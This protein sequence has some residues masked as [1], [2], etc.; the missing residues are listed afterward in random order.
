MLRRPPRFTR[1]D[2]LFPYTTLF[3]SRRPTR[4]HSQFRGYSATTSICSPGPL[5]SRSD[6]N[7]AGFDVGRSRYAAPDVRQFRSEEHTSELQSLMRISYAVFCL[8]KNKEQLNSNKNADT[9]HMK[10][11]ET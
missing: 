10:N 9:L 7:L 4:L 8:T 1:T 6:C 5:E 2:P 3:R 11:N